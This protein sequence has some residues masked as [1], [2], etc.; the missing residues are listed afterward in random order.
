MFNGIKV[1]D[2]WY[3]KNCSAC[4][5]RPSCFLF[6]PICRIIDKKYS[7]RMQFHLMFI[8]STPLVQV[9]TTVQKQRNMGCSNI[10]VLVTFLHFLYVSVYMQLFFFSTDVASSDSLQDV[11]TI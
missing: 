5:E 3:K 11:E 6:H 1:C 4:F 8:I 9:C 7:N 2:C 10:F